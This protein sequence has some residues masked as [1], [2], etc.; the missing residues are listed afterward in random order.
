MNPAEKRSEERKL[1]TVTFDY[2][3]STMDRNR[4][5]QEK[6]LGI[7]TNI[8]PNGVGFLTNQPFSSGQ[9]I[10]IYNKNISNSPLSVQVRWCSRLSSS[11]YKVGASFN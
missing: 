5:H 3:Y 1:F 11:L 7:S 4:S 6:G 8:S 9:D 10:K 2:T